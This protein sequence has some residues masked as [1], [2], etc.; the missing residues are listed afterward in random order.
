MEFILKN[1]KEFLI[2]EASINRF[3]THLKNGD[4]IAAVSG[5]REGLNREERKKNYR[6]IKRLLGMAKFGYIRVKGG[7]HEENGYVDD[8]S[9][10]IIY[11]PKEREKELRDLVVSMGKR[12][13]QSSV[14]FIDT[15]GTAQYI[16]TRNDSW[17]GEIGTVKKLGAY[18][19]INPPEVA[20]FYTRIRGK[21]FT[22][23]TFEEEAEYN[24][25]IR[26]R[27]ISEWFCDSLKKYGENVLDEWFKNND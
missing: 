21:K 11:A 1:Y 14:M 16:S 19:A 3:E 20:D 25:D 22:F 26:E 9:S 2:Q 4:V 15:K 23:K 12:F 5:D 7:Y 18:K 13:N 24:P 8:E 10:V 17:I 6:E 27:Q